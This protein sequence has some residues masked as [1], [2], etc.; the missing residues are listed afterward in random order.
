MLFAKAKGSRSLKSKPS[1]N[2]EDE[3]VDITKSL[4]S[5]DEENSFQMSKFEESRRRTAI[6]FVLEEKKQYLGT[7]ISEFRND[8][9]VYDMLDKLELL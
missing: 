3:T 1:E 7:Q 4:T 8:L 2:G 6:C 5:L 9:I